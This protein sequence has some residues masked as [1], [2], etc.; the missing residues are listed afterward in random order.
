MAIVIDVVYDLAGP[1]QLRR[2]IGR[3]RWPHIVHPHE[4]E[5]ARYVE[6]GEWMVSERARIS[7][8]FHVVPVGLEGLD[9]ER[10][11]IDIREIVV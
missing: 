7:H 11:Y 9:Y 2:S 3:E 4:M 6:V 8:V 5:I 1:G 10:E